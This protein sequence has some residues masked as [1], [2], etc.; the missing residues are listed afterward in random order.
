MSVG[1][2]QTLAMTGATGF[3]GGATLSAA[4]A[5][6]YT[7]RAL[8]RRPQPERAGVRWIAGD[9]A[10]KTALDTLCEGADAI[11]HIAGATN[12]PSRE[13]FEAG[14][15]DAV[16]R[17]IAAAKARGIERFIHVSSLAARRPQL[18]IYGETKLAGERLVAN[19]SLAWTAVRPPAVY[20]PGDQEML[21]LFRMARRGLVFL[22]PRGRLSAI[23]VDDLARLLIDLVPASKAT[24]GAIYEADDGTRNG[25]SHREFARLIGQAVGR[26]VRSLSIPAPLL[27]LA[28]HADRLVRGHKAKLTPDRARYFAHPDWT[29]DPDSRPPSAVWTPRIATAEGLAATAQWYRKQGWI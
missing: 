16:L 19:S 11:V 24:G 20:G 23:H 8:T 21:E 1:G 15:V 28:G 2:G 7:V 14:N 12:A 29:V 5:S 26:G 22:P 17:M 25:W 6:G 9:L 27:L 10:D 3:V 18:S 4:L 13:G